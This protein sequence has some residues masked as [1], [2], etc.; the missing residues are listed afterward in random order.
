M[1][2]NATQRQSFQYFDQKG[3]IIFKSPLTINRKFKIDIKN[4]VYHYLNIVVNDESW[5]WHLR[6]GHLN[7]QSLK[8]LAQNNM[9]KDL[10]VIDYSN[11]FYK[12]CIFGKQHRRSFS[13]H[14]I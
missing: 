9:V 3:K 8:L 6:F 7:F 12:G 4:D 5:L 10:P 1:I 13:N 11:Q 2:Q 14:N